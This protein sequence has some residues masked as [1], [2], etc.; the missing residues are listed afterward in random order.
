MIS[1]KARPYFAGMV[2]DLVSFYQSTG[3]NLSDTQLFIQ[4]SLIFG[5]RMLSEVCPNLDLE[6]GECSVGAIEVM[7]EAVERMNKG[8]KEIQDKIGN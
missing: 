8:A 4:I 2:D 7:K 1:D 3:K 5:D 6:L